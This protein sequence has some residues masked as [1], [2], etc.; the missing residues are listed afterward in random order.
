VSVIISQ[1]MSHHLDDAQLAAMIGEESRLLRDD[2]QLV[3]LDAVWSRRRPLSRLLWRYDRGA[4]PRSADALVVALD[5]HF[6]PVRPP[7][8]FAVWH[9]YLLWVGQPRRLTPPPRKPDTHASATQTAS[10]RPTGNA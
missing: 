6:E 10:L 3:F 5:R 8:Y 4:F 7:E 1:N 9:E 2:G